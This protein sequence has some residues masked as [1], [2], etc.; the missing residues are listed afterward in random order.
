MKGGR[1]APT[2]SFPTDDAPSH[3]GILAT[4]SANGS[5][6]TMRG[7]SFA[8]AQAARELVYSLFDDPSAEKSEKARLAN[9][10]RLQEYRGWPHGNGFDNDLIEVLGA[11]RIP[12]PIQP[13]RK[14]F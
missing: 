12:S 13:R 7:T 11:G 5:T 6:V 2:A 4:G 3:F 1:Y 8:S 9:I 14:R 10:A